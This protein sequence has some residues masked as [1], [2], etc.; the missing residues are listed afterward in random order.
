[1]Y[2]VS[3]LNV[4]VSPV[5]AGKIQTIPYDLWSPKPLFPRCVTPFQAVLQEERIKDLILSVGEEGYGAERFTSL[6]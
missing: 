5:T 4:A 2:T 1:M 6:S 3:L